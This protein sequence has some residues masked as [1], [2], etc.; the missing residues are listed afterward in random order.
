VLQNKPRAPGSIG[1]V[2]AAE[3]EAIVM[4]ALRNHLSTRDAG[5]I[6]PDDD[7]ELVDRHLERVALTPNEIKLRLRE[8]VQ[9]VPED[10]EAHDTENNSSERT[11][12]NVK[13]I[14]VAWTKPMPAAVKGVIHVPAHNTPMTP[15]GREAL[16]IAIAKARN[17]IDDL[18]HGRVASFAAIAHREG[19]IERRIR[20]LMPLGFLSPRIVSAIL[21]GAAP[22]DLTVTRLTR[23][24]PYSWAEQERWLGTG[25]VSDENQGSPAS[26]DNV[27]PRNSHSR[28]TAV[29]EPLCPPGPGQGA[30][31]Y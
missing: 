11:I 23:P 15:S 6:L 9:E 26:S 10:L 30:D 31:D 20:L 22:A 8:I 25:T 14:S 2:P 27:A 21:D 19:K 12:V 4:A 29:A 16:L 5:Q 17:W 13:A 3:L 18:A 1:R 7:R 28:Y 24:L